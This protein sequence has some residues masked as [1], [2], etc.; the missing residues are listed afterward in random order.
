MKPLLAVLLLTI[1]V[2]AASIVNGGQLLTQSNANQLATWLGQ[3]D[4]TFTNVFSQT[5][6]SNGS[7]LFHTASDGIGPTFT[8]FQTNLGLVGGYD[9]VSW[10]SSGSYITDPTNTGRTAF[11]F[12]LSTTTLLRQLLGDSNGQYQT[13]NYGPYGPTF[14]GG[15]DLT[16]NSSNL[17]NGYAYSFSYGGGFSQPNI[18]GLSSSSGNP[19]MFT[20]SRVETYTF[21][22]AVAQTAE[23]STFLLCAGALMIL[24]GL[25]RRFQNANPAGHAGLRQ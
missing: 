18:F 20:V 23:P 24:C 2:P 7:T 17:S 10:N 16:V 9:P 8:L 1:P 13:F 12:N 5:P 3:G 4:L 21:A 25:G 22:P 19:T 6:I 15:H 11:I 14:G